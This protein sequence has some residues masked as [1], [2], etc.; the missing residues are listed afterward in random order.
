MKKYKNCLIV[1]SALF[2]GSTILP[3]LGYW[4]CDY[5][6]VVVSYYNEMTE[7]WET[8]TYVET[9]NCRWR[10][11]FGSSPEGGFI[12]DSD[13]I[14]PPGGG[15]P[16][17]DPDPDPCEEPPAPKT[18]AFRQHFG[19]SSASRLVIFDGVLS[20]AI[21]GIDLNEDGALSGDME[22]LGFLEDK[23]GTGFH[24]PLAVLP[25]FDRQENGGNGDGFLNSEDEVWSRLVFWH[26]FDGDMASSS[27]EIIS[28]Q[29]VCQD[30]LVV[31]TV[32]ETEDAESCFLM[33]DTFSGDRLELIVRSNEW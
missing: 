21:V 4:G 23:Q 31:P 30:I 13:L 8:D 12:I 25:V 22:L 18:S 5:E 32:S 17:P 26:D 3:A 11:M 2:L 14:D 16:D 7:R 15:D 9:T 20:G 33:T 27:P 10:T 24:T 29:H 28:L 6:I 19:D 1:V